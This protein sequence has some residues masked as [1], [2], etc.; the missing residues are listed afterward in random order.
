M[1]PPAKRIEGIN[2]DEELYFAILTN[3]IISYMMKEQEEP[4]RQNQ[5]VLFE[6]LRD[7]RLFHVRYT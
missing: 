4:S 6:L 2:A 1:R 7:E 3:L 5:K